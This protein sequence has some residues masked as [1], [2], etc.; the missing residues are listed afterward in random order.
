MPA[1]VS[2]VQMVA[3]D[4]LLPLFAADPRKFGSALATSP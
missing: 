1:G 3:W 4:G 2:A